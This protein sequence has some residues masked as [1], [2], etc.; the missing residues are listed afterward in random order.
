MSYYCG[1][2]GSKLVS[3]RVKNGSDLDTGTKKWVSYKV[4]VVK[5][6]RR[7]KCPNGCE[8][9]TVKQD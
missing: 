6:I 9:K 8:L 2:C 7:Y 5:T 4:L 1:N 3:Q